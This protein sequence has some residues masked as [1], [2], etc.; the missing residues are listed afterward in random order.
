MTVDWPGGY[1]REAGSSNL[2]DRG[3]LPETHARP[4]AHRASLDEAG[5]ER[6]IEVRRGYPL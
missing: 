3:I 5:L 1:P 2:A 4:E 6:A